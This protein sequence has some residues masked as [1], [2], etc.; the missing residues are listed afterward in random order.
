MTLIVPIVEGHG[1]RDA[2]P[3]LL[4]RV[5]RTANPTATVK[6]NEPIRVAS[7]SFLNNVDYFRKYVLLGAAK[8]GQV[9][10]GHLLI[11]LDC[12]D[13]CPAELG[14]A[15]HCKAREFAPN[16]N[17]IVCLA[18]REYETWFVAA[19]NSL[20]GIGG[21]SQD[22]EAPANPEG[23]RNAKGWLGERMVNNYDPITHQLVFTRV[24][25]L[26]A[27][28]AVASFDRLCQK[29]AALV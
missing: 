27:A 25:D 21:M 17:V 20:R 2:V 13:Q 14:P 7:G 28:R 29:V 15:L 11:L 18:H 1:E 22:V 9:N 23:S 26:N 16:T 19:A 24:F 6:V 8:A 12:E 5:V 10:D 3:S 4:H